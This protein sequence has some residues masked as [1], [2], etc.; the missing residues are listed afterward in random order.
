MRSGPCS[1]SPLGIRNPS[2]GAGH[3][4]ACAA[5]TAATCLRRSSRFIPTELGCWTTNLNSVQNERTA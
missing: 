1:A 2:C 4:Y 5:C 3:V